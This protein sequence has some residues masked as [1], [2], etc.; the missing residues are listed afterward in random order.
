MGHSVSIVTNHDISDESSPFT[1]QLFLSTR[2]EVFGKYVAYFARNFDIIGP[3]DSMLRAT[4]WPLLERAATNL[5]R[6]CQK[7][8]RPYEDIYYRISLRNQRTWKM[9]LGIRVPH[10]T[11][12]QLQA[13]LA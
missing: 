11:D 4:P 13:P 5:S 8:F 9:R 12:M 3:D 2:P 10:D 7:C 1:A 6:A